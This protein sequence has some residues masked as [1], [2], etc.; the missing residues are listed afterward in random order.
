MS[1]FTAGPWSIEESEDTPELWEVYKKEGD[2]YYKEILKTYERHD[3]HLIAAAPEMYENL[4]LAFTELACVR[5]EVA[6][7]KHRERIGKLLDS[8]RKVMDSASGE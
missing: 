3:A 7:D 6:T 2:S 8:M 4:K 5:C 1:K